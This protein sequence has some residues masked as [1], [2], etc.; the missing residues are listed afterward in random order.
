[1]TFVHPGDS[2][3]HSLEILDYLYEYDEFMESIRTVV[4]LGCGAGDDLAWWATRT[5]KGDVPK[6]LNIR[7][8]GIDLAPQLLI[9]GQYNNVLYQSAD[10]ENT[11]IPPQNGFDVFWCHDSFQ[12]AQNPIKTLSNWWHMGSPGA[13]LCLSIP[14]TQHIHRNQ[15]DYQLPSGCYYHHTMVSL[16]YQLSTAGWDC[17]AGFFKQI[18][19]EPWIHAVVYK[20]ETP[21]QDP[22]ITSWHTLAELKLLPKS[23]EQSIYLHNC[24][25]QQDLIVPW[26]D[27]SLISMALQ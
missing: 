5:T 9:A 3:K 2:H 12:Y 7:C 23:A 22:K 18:P 4:D 17:G 20:S 13:M 24:L 16:I 19:Q 14:T 11:I 25:R 10:F 26:L 6:P 27:R 1:M 8:T 15:I 21:P